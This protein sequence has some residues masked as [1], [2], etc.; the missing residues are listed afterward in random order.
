VVPLSRPHTDERIKRAELLLQRRFDQDVSVEA[1]AAELNMS[2]RNLLRRFTTATGRLP[3]E[4]LQLLRV[5]AARE[6]PE[7]GRA[8]VQNVSFR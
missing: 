5:G 2:A 4:Y 8:P 6:F 3:G 7:R 1:V